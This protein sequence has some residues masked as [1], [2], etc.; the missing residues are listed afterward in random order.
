FDNV[1]ES[2][3]IG[4]QGLDCVAAKGKQAFL[5]AFPQNFYN[6]LVPSNVLD[7]GAADFTRAAACTPH[8]LDQREVSRIVRCRDEPPGFFHGQPLRKTLFHA[9]IRNMSSRRILTSTKVVEEV[10]EAAQGVRASCHRRG[11]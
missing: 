4:L 9:L 10:E 8:E 3:Q 1:R 11:G 7:P 6:S 2:S 5:L